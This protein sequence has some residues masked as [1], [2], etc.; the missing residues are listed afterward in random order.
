MRMSGEVFWVTT[1][2]RCTSSGRRESTRETRFCTWIWAMSGS[3]CW[4]KVMVRIIRPSVADCEDMYS[5]PST[6]VIACSSGVA[7]VCAITS[8]LAPG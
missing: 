5:I 7:T 3:M 1:P 4:S 2:C 8:G 6:P